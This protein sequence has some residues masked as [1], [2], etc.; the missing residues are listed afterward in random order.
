MDIPSVLLQFGGSLLAILGLFALTKFLKLGGK[1]RQFTEESVRFAAAEVEDGFIAS[2]IA[3]TRD[4]V[5]AL[6]SNSQGEMMVIKR[7]GN[8]AAGRLLNSDTRVQEEVDAIIVDCR[9]AHFG[10]VKLSIEQPG[11]WVDAINRL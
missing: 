8:K 4:G 9:D 2:S 10:K 1:A 11:I 6:A 7:H 5:A 3:I